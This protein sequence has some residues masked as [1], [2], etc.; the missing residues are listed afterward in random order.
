MRKKMSIICAL[1]VSSILYSQEDTRELL[2]I[3]GDGASVSAA[4]KILHNAGGRE[5]WSKKTFIVYERAF[6]RSGKIANLKITR[7]L[8]KITRLIESKTDDTV[9]MEYIG[10]EN[11]CTNRN[12]ERAEMEKSELEVERQGLKQ[13]PYYVYHRL[14]K[15]DSNLRVELTENENRLNVYD[16]DQLLCWFLID[17][18]GQQYS[19]GNI[20]NGAIN[21]H[22]YGPYKKMGDAI[23]PTW[24]SAM[25]GGFRFEYL[26]SEFRDGPAEISCNLL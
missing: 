5:V 8:E 3:S 10:V 26:V 12:G 6:L 21:Q 19:W 9:Y 20:Y 22:F 14:A 1:V 15:E 13:S 4:S 11:G 18:T 16:R 24:G 7:D 25:D 17:A 23:L 2:G